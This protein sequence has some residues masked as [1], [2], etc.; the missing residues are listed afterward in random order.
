[1]LHKVND[2]SNGSMEFAY[3]PVRVTG[4]RQ[5]AALNYGVGACSILFTYILHGCGRFLFLGK[6]GSKLVNLEQIMDDTIQLPLAV[7]LLSP[8]QRKA[9]EPLGMAD[10]C[11]RWLG[12]GEALLIDQPAL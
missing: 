3:S 6:P 12:G 2:R 7:D 1:M 8:T 11:K 5:L 9:I 4:H 10:I